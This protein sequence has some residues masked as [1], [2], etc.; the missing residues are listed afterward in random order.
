MVKGL[1][2][3]LIR[4]RYYPPYP[5]LIA[6]GLECPIGN[7]NEIWVA[8]EKVICLGERN[9]STV[10]DVSLA[11]WTKSHQTIVVYRCS[12]EG[13]Q[14]SG[15]KQLNVGIWSTMCETQV[16]CRSR[17]DAVR[18]LRRSYNGLRDIEPALCIMMNVGMN[19][20]IVYTRQPMSLSTSGWGKL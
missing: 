3:K 12:K 2:V 7:A 4:L 10:N 13:Q 19:M 5:L 14:G 17:A 16:I 1:E 15:G 8:V 11:W 6:I 9:L 18:S 20:D